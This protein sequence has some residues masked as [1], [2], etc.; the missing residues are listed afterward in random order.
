M[1]PLLLAVL[2]LSQ[3]ADTI[4]YAIILSGNRAGSEVAIR[5]PDG[6]LHFFQEY[7]DRG[8]GPK[9][10][11]RFTLTADGMPR[12]VSITGNDYLKVPVEERFT[13]RGDTA[14]WSS[15]AERGSRYLGGSRARFMCR[16]TGPPARTSCSLRP[17]QRQRTARFRSCLRAARESKNSSSAR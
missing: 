7:N 14:E 4:R 15:S 9:L 11:S 8:R 13:L 2:L 6:T 12:T 5:E 1:T 17:E 10:E 16:S 3:R